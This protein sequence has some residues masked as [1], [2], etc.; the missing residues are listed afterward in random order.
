MLDR[1]WRGLPNFS[2]IKPLPMQTN[3]SLKT[4]K[5]SPL[6]PL[7]IA[8]VALL[9]TQSAPAHSLAL[10]EVSSTTLTATY[11]GST[12]TVTPNGSDDWI[13]TAAIITFHSPGLEQ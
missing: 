6:V 10:T 11:D 7:A 1:A 3:T 2:S 13:V 9:V 5:L 4:F 12:L 8:I